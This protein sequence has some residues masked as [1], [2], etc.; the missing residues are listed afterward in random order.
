MEPE[1]LDG[2]Q[3]QIIS[4]LLKICTSGIRREMSK[5]GDT[6]I[7][8]TYCQLEADAAATSVPKLVYV[9]SKNRIIDIKH[10]I[11]ITHI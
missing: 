3:L 5:K 8:L 4:N 6:V 9:D 11:D 2:M 10:T 1:F 7:I